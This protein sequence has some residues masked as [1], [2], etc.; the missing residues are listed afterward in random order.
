MQLRRPTQS[1]LGHYNELF[2]QTDLVAVTVIHIISFCGII[3]EAVPVLTWVR[4]M[5]I[6]KL[7][8]ALSS[9]CES[10]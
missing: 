3:D 1:L 10:F 4:A 7:L 6:I 8:T 5:A 9:H 2:T